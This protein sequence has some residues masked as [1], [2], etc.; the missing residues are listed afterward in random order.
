MKTK[1]FMVIFILTLFLTVPFNMEDVYGSE[2]VKGQSIIAED[3]AKA[4]MG[5]NFPGLNITWLDIGDSHIQVYSQMDVFSGGIFTLKLSEQTIRFDTSGKIIIATGDYDGIYE[6]SDGMAKVYN[7]VLSDEP[8]VPGSIFA[9]PGQMEGFIDSEGNEVIPIGK[10]YGLGDKFHEG[11]TTIGGYEQNKGF[12]NK[13]G[14]IV[15]PQ[16]YK[17]AGDFSE[18]LAAVQSVETELWGYI[19]KDGEIVIPMMYEAAKPFREEAAYVVKDGLAGYID[20]EGNNIIDFKL[21]PE[22]DR[23]ADNSFYGGLAVAQ[24]NSGKYGYIDKSGDF[25]I[26]AKYKEANPFIGEVV[27]VVIENQNYPNGYGSSFLINRDGERL[28]PL[29]QYGRYDGE[30]MRD[31]LIR[32]LSTYGP[33]SNESIVML[34]K[35]GAEVIPASL[36]IKYLS[37][38]NEGYALLIAHNNGGTAVGLVEKPE[39]I[40]A[41]RDRKLIRVFIDD[42]LLDFEDTDPV[43]ENSRTLVPMRAIFEAL[44][45]DVEWDDANKTAVATKDDITISLKI[46]ENIAYIND[47]P[48]EL[49]VPA[50]IKNSRTLV[51]I[52]F[53]AESFNA[54][55][56]WDD[57]LRAVT[58]EFVSGQEVEISESTKSLSTLTALEVMNLAY[59]EVKMITGEEPLLNYLTSTDDTTASLTVNDGLDGKRNAWNMSFGSASGNMSITASV[60]DGICYKGDLVTDDNNLLIKGIFSISDIKMDSTEAVNKSIELFDMKPGNPEIEDDW[61]KGY[62][63]IITDYIIDPSLNKTKLLLRVTGISPNSP[64]SNN[65]SLRMNV[66]FDVSTG[67]VFSATEQTGYDEEGR[68]AWREI[69]LQ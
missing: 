44:G 15:I 30:N 47:K 16:I 10:F 17:D 13:K 23:Y 65:E 43:I 32:A 3:Q 55:V 41:Y 12:I 49:D 14:E 45:A 51:P 8:H 57:I 36:N 21:K 60:R 24:D 6:F 22:T 54:D 7:Y 61:I 67:E 26:P 25:V 39:N 42:K 33:S 35:Y 59:E 68:S 62:H 11:F 1:I 4:S 37:P 66:F 27:F 46:D 18:G 52:R 58:I 56:E 2:F 63:F 5:L 34:N 31:G 69:D 19:D 64:N 20:K 40:E 29:W 28:T 48:M 38:F 9:P 53:I 50:R